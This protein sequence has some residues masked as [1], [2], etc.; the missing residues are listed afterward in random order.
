[1]RVAAAL[2]ITLRILCACA[3][4]ARTTCSDAH[5]ASAA[6]LLTL[7]VVCS[8][9]QKAAGVL[10]H[11]PRAYSVYACRT[12]TLS[13]F[14][15]G[16]CYN[17]FWQTHE[18][19]VSCKNALS[20]V[21]SLARGSRLSDAE[22]ESVWR[23]LN[24]AHVTGYVGLSH[25]YTRVNLLDGLCLKYDLFGDSR[26]TLSRRQSAELKRITELEVDGASG[27]AGYGEF[28][29]WTL[30][31]ISSATARGVLDLA[32]KENMQRLVMQMR[33]GMTGLYDYQFQVRGRP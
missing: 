16:Y 5:A 25:V 6:S 23:W 31:L 13:V 11:L 8:T 15:F 1:M 22:V 7:S 2:N 4:G 26:S 12:P 19:A 30:R 24:L 33:A 9:L 14:Y 10:R 32:D 3:S 21:V 27:S 18:L 29:V 20:G 28:L 17:R